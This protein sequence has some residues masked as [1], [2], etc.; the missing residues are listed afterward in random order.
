[1]SVDT[2]EFKSADCNSSGQ[3]QARLHISNLVDLDKKK[4]LE[5]FKRLYTYLCLHGMYEYVPPETHKWLQ[6]FLGKTYL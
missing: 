6:L 1:M 2:F 5:T 3:K 4:Y